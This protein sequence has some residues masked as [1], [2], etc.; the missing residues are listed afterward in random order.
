MCQP[1]VRSHTLPM[2]HCV[3]VYVSAKRKV[4][5][6][7]H[8]SYGVNTHVS[9]DACWVTWLYM[10]LIFTLSALF[11]LLSILGWADLGAK[12][13]GFFWGFFFFS[14]LPQFG[15]KPTTT[16]KVDKCAIHHMTVTP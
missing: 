5:D 8:V 16:W 12:V 6:P 4:T 3:A 7:V 14:I 11:F 2:S 9:V 13:N 1:K 10:P 15:I